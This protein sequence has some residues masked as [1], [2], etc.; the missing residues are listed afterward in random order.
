VL[1]F[2]SGEMYSTTSTRPLQ[3][4]FSCFLFPVILCKLRHL[5]DK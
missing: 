2:F 3:A 5:S 4:L 1:L